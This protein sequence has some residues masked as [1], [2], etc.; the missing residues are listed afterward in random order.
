[1]NISVAG[2]GTYKGNCKAWSAGGG[3]E[4]HPR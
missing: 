2:G 3:R 1:M 4:A